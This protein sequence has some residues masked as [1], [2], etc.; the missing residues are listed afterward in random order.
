[1]RGPGFETFAN[2]LQQRVVR[3]LKRLNLFEQLAYTFFAS[4][5]QFEIGCIDDLIDNLATISSN[6]AQRHRYRQVA[7]VRS[8]ID[9]ATRQK[10]Q[11]DQRQ[12]SNKAHAIPEPEHASFCWTHFRQQSVIEGTLDGTKQQQLQFPKPLILVVP[13]LRG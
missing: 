5:R 7:K 4:M 10:L 11:H 12:A 9:V 8:M 1:L 13:G 3:L 6:N 2:S